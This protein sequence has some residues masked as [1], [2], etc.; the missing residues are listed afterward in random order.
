MASGFREVQLVAVEQEGER[1]SAV[2][3]ES[4]DSR[5]LVAGRGLAASR[6]E[7]RL[8]AS[9]AVYDG[10]QAKQS[11]D[12][13]CFFF[14]SMPCNRVPRSSSIAPSFGL[15]LL[16]SQASTNNDQAVAIENQVPRTPEQF[17]VMFLFLRSA[18]HH[19]T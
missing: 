14:R 5:W 17:C 8:E 15:L 13:F 11:P 3:A 16:S 2:A 7:R 9:A 10:E 12:P 18:E 4:R 6:E 1:G 19:N